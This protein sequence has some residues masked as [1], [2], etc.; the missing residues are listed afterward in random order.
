M[1]KEARKF[2]QNQR[3]KNKNNSIKLVIFLIFF[4]FNILHLVCTGILL[5]FKFLWIKFHWKTAMLF[6]FPCYLDS[7]VLTLAGMNSCIRGCLVLRACTFSPWPFAESLLFYD[8]CYWTSDH[9]QVSLC[10]WLNLSGVFDL[11]SLLYPEVFIRCLIWTESTLAD[12]SH[13]FCP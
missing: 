9:L 13:Q 4:F 6:L 10:H 3:I 2:N 8:M 12:D 7:F 11:P 1:K 5:E